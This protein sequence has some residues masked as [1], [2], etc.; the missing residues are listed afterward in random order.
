VVAL[1][2]RMQLA[3]RIPLR[4]AVPVYVAAIV[5]AEALVAYGSPLAGILIDALVVLVVLNQYLVERDRLDASLQAGGESARSL[6]VLL[7]LPLVPILRICSL[8]MTVSVV[9][10]LE[11]YVVVGVPVLAAALSTAALGDR[12]RLVALF[13][14]G[15]GRRQAVIGLTGLPLGLLA[16]LA[17]RPDPVAGSTSLA[18]I[19]AGCVILIVFSG[20]LEELVF[21]GLLQDAFCSRYGPAGQLV[22]GALFAAVYLGAGSAA[23]VLVFAAI[24][25]AFGFAVSRTRSIVGVVAAHGLLSIGLVLVWPHVLG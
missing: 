18:Q 23:A 24:G 4:G 22:S 6:A 16:Y 25:L 20:L 8:T 2:D 19:A 17:L 1:S 9:P 21:R 13:R 3:R 7:V 5:T 15:S 12:A 10:E 11:Q 14:V